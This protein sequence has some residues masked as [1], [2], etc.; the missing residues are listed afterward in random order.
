MDTNVLVRYYVSDV[1]DAATQRQ[2]EQARD[3]I[4]SGEAL[5]VCQTVMLELEWVLRGYYQLSRT[6]VLAAL[7][8]LLSLAHV[9]FDDRRLLQQ[10][11]ENFAAGLDF[12]DALHHANYAA[13]ASVLSFDERG[14][15]RR[16]GKLSLSPA[17]VLPR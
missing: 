12:A 13:C 1:T 6:Q 15:V 2:R 4:E 10:A 16:S 17:V 3:L 11:I 7:Q 5:A 14:F 8:H 9:T